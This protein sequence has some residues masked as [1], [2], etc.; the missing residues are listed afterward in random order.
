M[1]GSSLKLQASVVASKSSTKMATKRLP[2]AA[3]EQKPKPQ[4]PNPKPQTSNLI[5]GWCVR[6]AQRGQGRTAVPNMQWSASSC[7]WCHV[8]HTCVTCHKQASHVTH[9]RHMSHTCVTCH[10]CEQY[11]AEGKLLELVV[12]ATS[13]VTR[14]TSHVTSCS[15][16]DDRPVFMKYSLVLN[17]RLGLQCTPYT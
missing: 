6:N 1:L 2:V 15:L 17:S 4:T 9:K 12:M 13:H 7:T 5:R 10:T 8:L 16:S 14:H 3:R 11:A